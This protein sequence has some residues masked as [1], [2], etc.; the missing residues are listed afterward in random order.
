MNMQSHAKVETKARR[1]GTVLIFAVAI[2]ALLAVMGTAYL[3]MARME[4]GSVRGESDSV[5]L[6]YARDAVLNIAREV[7]YDC[8]TDSSGNILNYLPLSTVSPKARFYDYPENNGNG[9]ASID[10]TIPDE[11]WLSNG[12]AAGQCLLTNGAAGAPKAY[13]PNTGANDLAFTANSVAVVDP[14]NATLDAP[15]HLLTLSTPGGIRYR[16]GVVIQDA[17]SRANLNTGDLDSTLIS[18]GDP[19]G[20]LLSSYKLFS[21]TSGA[22]IFNVADTAVKLQTPVAPLV[23]RSG[24]SATSF[25]LGYWQGQ[26]MSM[27]SPGDTAVAFFDLTDELELRSNGTRGTSY[28]ARPATIWTNT[29]GAGAANRA[30][31]TTYSW[32]RNYRTQA[33]PPGGVTPF[34]L[35]GGADP[36]WPVYPRKVNLNQALPGTLTAA[37]AQTAATTASNIA[38]AMVASGYT[39]S[40]AAA[41]AANYITYRYSQWTNTAAGYRLQQGPAIVDGSGIVVPTSTTTVAPFSGGANNLRAGISPDAN[42]LYVGY[43]AQPFLNE[44]ACVAVT[45][46]PNTVTDWAVEIANPYHVALDVSDYR[47]TDSPTGAG[48]IVYLTTGT[49]GLNAAFTSGVPPQTTTSTTFGTP[50]VITA[51]GSGFGASVAGAHYPATALAT[52]LIN[53]AGGTVY[54]QRT[55][56]DRTGTQQWVTVD[57]ISYLAPTASAAPGTTTSVARSND[58]ASGGN[59][60]DDFQVANGVTATATGTTSLGAVNAPIGATNINSS[61]LPNVG[62]PSVRLYDAYIDSDHTPSNQLVPGQALSNFGDFC[63]IGRI[64]NNSSAPVASQIQIISLISSFNASAFPQ[65]AQVHF[66]FGVPPKYF[67]PPYTATNADD[68]RTVKLLDYIDMTDRSTDSTINIGGGATDINK[69]RIPGRINVNTATGPVLMGIPGMSQ[70]MAQYILA[71][72]DRISTASLAAPFNSGTA[73]VFTSAVTYPGKGIRS[74][75]ELLYVVQLAAVNNATPLSLD[76]Q[77][78][79]GNA[80]STGTT[81]ANGYFNNIMNYCTVRSDTFVVYGYIDAVQKNPQYSGAFNN[82]TAGGSSDWYENTLISDTPS[83]SDT[84]DKLFRVAKRRFIAVIDRSFANSPRGNAL[85]QLPKVVAVKDMPF[86]R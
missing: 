70:K 5:S 7:M 57:S 26:L 55:Y 40:E 2:L 74:L 82:G 48:N 51:S 16:F 66:D 47:L 83:T 4:R 84:T 29:L 44:V 25:S 20:T 31:Y 72:R 85:F 12:A 46:T 6:D 17:S 60:T 42:T 54:L 80:T 30:Y 34:T 37:G 41:F 9:K 36:I 19:M 86:D 81:P 33:D 65:D 23:G 43:A 15:L 62:S 68:S 73:K 8:A 59:G 63:R 49:N 64:A 67:T 53:A 38:T 75:G 3:L 56:L 11:P 32:T 22:P 13:D 18:S 1:R 69:L 77:Y 78:G 52:P 28:V 10:A 76:G 79:P 14:R 27:E 35:G 21:A 50:I 39:T 45:G 58:N 61:P 71:Y 24:S